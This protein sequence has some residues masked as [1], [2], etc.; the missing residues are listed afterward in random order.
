MQP[1]GDDAGIPFRIR[2]LELVEPRLRLGVGRE[3][4]A[5]LAVGGIFFGGLNCAIDA[6]VVGIGFL[7]G[8]GEQAG[9]MVDNK[10]PR[11][12]QAFVS[13]ALGTNTGA[14]LGTSTVTSSLRLRRCNSRTTMPVPKPSIPLESSMYGMER[15][16]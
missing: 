6:E 2:F 11:A 7:L 13:D 9:L 16:L 8:V 14:A 3:R 5:G 15:R 1:K 10:L 4:F 12:K